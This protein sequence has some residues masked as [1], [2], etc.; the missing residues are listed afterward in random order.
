MKW[1]IP[2]AVRPALVRVV[3]V[4]TVVGL[5]AAGLLPHDVAAVLLG[6]AAT[7]AATKP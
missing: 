4:L 7:E 3:V 1:R 2:A 6:G 5:S